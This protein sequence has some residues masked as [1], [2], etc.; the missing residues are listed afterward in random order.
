VYGRGSTKTPGTLSD[1]VFNALA[2]LA[3]TRPTTSEPAMNVGKATAA[4]PSDAPDALTTPGML[5]TLAFNAIT[6]LAPTR[7]TTSDPA[8]NVGRTADASPSRA[9]D[10]LRI[11]LDIRLEIWDQDRRDVNREVFSHSGVFCSNTLF[12]RSLLGVNR[13]LRNETFA[14]ADRYFCKVGTKISVVCGQTGATTILLVV[15]EML[16]LGYAYD[17]RSIATN[18]APRPGVLDAFTRKMPVMHGERRYHTIKAGTSDS[19][20]TSYVSPPNSR[21]GVD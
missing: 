14:A 4:A 5:T 17:R 12:T 21:Y 20:D 18:G 11:P 2:T 10:L 7:P 19:H 13:A 6:T 16:H 15:L 3:P 8:M 1:L 9:L